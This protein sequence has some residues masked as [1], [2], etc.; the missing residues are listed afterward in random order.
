MTTIEGTIKY[1]IT[2]DENGTNTEYESTLENDIAAMAIAE[3]VCGEWINH[4]KEEKS[5][6]EGKVKAKIN[7]RLLKTVQTQKGLKTLGDYA[8]AMYKAFKGFEEV[9]ASADAQEA[10]E[11]PL[12]GSNEIEQV[13]IITDL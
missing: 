4:I 10:N 2:L 7:D 8:F 1:K 3:F 5:N 13:K 9:R 6:H 12:Q 11:K